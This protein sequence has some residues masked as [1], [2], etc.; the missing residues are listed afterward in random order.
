MASDKTYRLALRCTELQKEL[1]DRFKKLVKKLNCD[2][3]SDELRNAA[4]LI[5]SMATIKE[6]ATIV[7]W[8]TL[9]EVPNDQ[10]T[11]REFTRKAKDAICIYGANAWIEAQE[12][13]FLLP[14]KTSIAIVIADLKFHRFEYSRDFWSFIEPGIAPQ[15]IVSCLEDAFIYASLKYPGRRILLVGGNRTLM[16]SKQK[17]K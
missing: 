13:S 10:I 3:A 15:S 6:I 9:E 1:L 11:R 8:E 5:L 2:S 14:H 4:R 16:K 12:R 17:G 7:H